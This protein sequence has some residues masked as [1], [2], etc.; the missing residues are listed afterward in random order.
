MPVRH[1]YIKQYLQNSSKPA[2]KLLMNQ[3]EL[4]L[5]PK[6]VGPYSIFITPVIVAS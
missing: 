5:Y 4:Y 6:P 2:V 1:A 3:S